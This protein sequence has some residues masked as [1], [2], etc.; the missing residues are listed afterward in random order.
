MAPDSDLSSK[1]SNEYAH[2]L[3]YNAR[4]LREQGSDAR[5]RQLEASAQEI[6]RLQQR[7]KEHEQ[8][9]HQHRDCDK[10]AVAL[11]AIKLGP[12][13]ELSNAEVAAWA[14]TVADRAFRGTSVETPAVTV[15]AAYETT[16]ATDKEIIPLACSQCSAT[17]LMPAANGV[18]DIRK[19]EGWHFSVVNGWR[20]PKCAAEKTADVLAIGSEPPAHLSHHR[21][22]VI[23]P[24]HADPTGT[25]REPPHCPSCSCGMADRHHGGTTVEER[26]AASRCQCGQQAW[27]AG[28]VRILDSLGGVHYATKPCT[29]ENGK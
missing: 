2:G 3:L 24:V 19:A 5:A 7:C 27:K 14:A 25:T 18:C 16:P 26:E 1:N 11:Q 21:G 10:L 13:V 12:P 8:F 6:E 15:A 4:Y 20:C 17:V 28:Y 9:R 29:T 22:A 23:V